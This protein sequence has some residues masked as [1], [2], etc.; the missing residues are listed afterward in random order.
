VSRYRRPLAVVLAAL[1]AVALSGCAT[2]RHPQILDIKNTVNGAE[3]DLAHSTI[4]VRNVYLT[5]PVAGQDLVAAQQKLTLHAY[6]FNN[7]STPDTLTGVTSGTTAARLTPPAGIT[8]PANNYVVIGGPS[9]SPVKASSGSPAP[10]V[11]WT[12]PSPVLV[13]TNISVQ[14]AF[15]N[16]GSVTLTVPVEYSAAANS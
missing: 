15:G 8:V 13:G 10:S 6:V 16:A 7:T 5:P 4:Q 14:L 11:T 3:A 9:S 2:G 1:A 12:T